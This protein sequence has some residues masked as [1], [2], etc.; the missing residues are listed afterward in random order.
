MIAD[1]KKVQSFINMAAD[2]A[3]SVQR[4]AGDLAALKAKW[5]VHRPSPVGTSLE[6]KLSAVNTWIAAIEA[7]AVDPVAADLLA[8]R[9][10]SHRGEA[11]D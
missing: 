7:L 6:G 4:V 8:A 11:L 5:R 9:V 2:V 10:L 1:T 3:E